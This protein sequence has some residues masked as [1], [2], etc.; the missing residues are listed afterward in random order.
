MKKIVFIIL[1]FVQ[2]FYGAETF[3]NNDL[4]N[5]CEKGVATKCFVIAEKY[6]ANR[7]IESSMKYFTKACN[8]GNA[9]ACYKLGNIYRFEIKLKNKKE[10]AVYYHKAC[11][12][13]HG[14]AC[15]NLG[16]L[17]K[18]GHGVQQDYQ[19][20]LE[21]FAK[22]CEIEDSMEK[23]CT[24]KEKLIELMKDL[25]ETKVNSFS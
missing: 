6:Y 14:K 2:N 25:N 11:D 20:A 8:L 23:G 22:A 17:Y 1:V 15:N 10:A 18:K 4:F 16:N 21:L 9:E 7:K 24:N 13:N 5:S 19:M 3:E 12:M